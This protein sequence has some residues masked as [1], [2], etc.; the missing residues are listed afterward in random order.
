MGRHEYDGL[1]DPSDEAP[2][3]R[4]WLLPVIAGTVF[5][6]VLGALMMQ[7][8]DVREQVRAAEQDNAVLADQ[9]RQLGG[10]PHVTP[11]AGPRGERGDAGPSGPP[12]PPGPSGRPGR[13][14]KDGAAGRPGRDG[15]PGPTGP[16]GPPGAQGI[17]GL[18]G[19]KGEPGQD[20]K[21]GAQGPKGEQGEP[22]PRGEPG[23]PGPAPASWTFTVAG[24]TYRCTPDAPESTTYT[25]T[26][27]SGG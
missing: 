24:V 17:P 23:P 21:D 18:P 27:T 10:V 20:G 7:V 15:A 16:P 25:C 4:S 22:G 9:V 13:D 3:H 11:S 1:D 2:R 12:G 14:G 26:P 6:A 5:A 19:P 8:F